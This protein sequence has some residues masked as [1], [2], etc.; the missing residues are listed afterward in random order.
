M[1]NFHR[2]G[3][4]SINRDTDTQNIRNYR[5][6]V[7]IGL[8]LALSGCDKGD[9]ITIVS[10]NQDTRVRV[11]V[12]HHT[13]GDFQD[14]LN[15]LTKRSD[16]PVSS[17]YLVPEPGD[18]S[19]NNKDLKLYSLVTEEARAWHAGTSYWAGKVALNDMSIGIE[20]VNQTYC[21]KS[22]AVIPPEAVDQTIER[23][24]FYPDFAEPQLE[25]LLDLLKGITERHTS[26]KPTHIVGHS[27][28]APQRKIDPGPRFPWQRLHRLGYGA[29]YDDETVF[30]YWE[31]LRDAPPSVLT[32][33]TAL[34]TYGYGIDLSGDHDLQSQNVVRAFQMHFLPWK[35]SSEFDAETVAILF[36]LIEKYYSSS[37]DTLLSEA[38]SEEELHVTQP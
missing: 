7:V 10:E 13:T 36:A 18:P 25:I 21:R 28:I 11:I 38:E 3:L 22:E 34:H 8:F 26:V 24:C 17:H 31:Q 16:Y 32:L 9:E 30:K 33:Q 14:S 20:L 1:T 15:V 35:V 19:Y 29:W 6:A 37:L 23:I 5:F 4:E 2:G 12:I 27:D